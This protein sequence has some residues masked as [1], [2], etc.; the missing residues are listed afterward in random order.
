[1]PRL[2][3]TRPSD[4]TPAFSGVVVRQVNRPKEGWT[5]KEAVD[6]LRQGYTVEHTARRTGFDARWL[7]A[8]LDPELG[9]S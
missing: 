3:A 7:A 9:G 5:E 2:G 4:G 1:M 8:Q 6:L